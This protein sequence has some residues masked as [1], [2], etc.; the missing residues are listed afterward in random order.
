MKHTVVIER[1]DPKSPDGEIR[2]KVAA[3]LSKLPDI[4]ARLGRAQSMRVWG[5][6]TVSFSKSTSAS[7]RRPPISAGRLTMWTPLC[8]TVLPPFCTNGP[9]PTCWLV[10]VAMGSR[11]P[12]PRQHGHMA[13]ID[14]VGFRFLDLHQ[15]PY[16]RFAVPQPAMFRWYDLSAALEEVDL[17]ISVAKMKA[18]HLC[19]LTLT[20]KNL[21]GL[22]PGP[23]YGSPRAA[24]HSQIRLPG[25]LADLSQLFPSEICLIDG[26]VGCNFQEWSSQGGDPVSSGILI[27]GNNPVA[28]DA[29]GARFMGID[30]AATLG[31]SPF[32][33][34]E[35]HIKLAAGL[36]LGSLEADDIDLVGD[37]PIERKPFS[38]SGASEAEV[39]ARED[40]YRHAV[41]RSAQQYFAD[42][43]RFVRDYQDQIVLFGNDRVLYHT[44]AAEFAF[45]AFGKALGAEG[46]GLYEGFLKLV[47]AEEAELSAPYTL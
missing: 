18:H 43:D 35:N 42:R 29:T 16:A 20:M 30:P 13:I 8:S 21:F 34:A 14:E 1:C 17:V 26:V 24:L 4:D 10:M 37:M 33:R 5:A 46:L 22:P 9:T 32:L 45:P 39:Y 7:G 38:V 41:C 12:R 31:T 23:I 11:P 44:P 28:T 6:L 47:Q 2:D 27:A 15:P 3:M 40:Q 19:G 25:I 36:G